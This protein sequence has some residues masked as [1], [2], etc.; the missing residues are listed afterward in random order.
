LNTELTDNP[1]ASVRPNARTAVG[2][3]AARTRQARRSEHQQKRR[4][5]PW[6]CG[7][8]AFCHH[9]LTC[10]CSR[11]RTTRPRVEGKG[12][13]TGGC[14][15]LRLATTYA[16]A[17]PIAVTVAHPG[18][19]TSGRCLY[20]LQRYPAVQGG[21]RIVWKSGVCLHQ[22]M[23]RTVVLASSRALWRPLVTSRRRA[24][25]LWGGA[26]S[27]WSCSRWE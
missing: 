10:R 7:R 4:A 22:S 27:T 2:L 11:K 9:H 24:W 3:R 14:D 25:Q 18:D 13:H 16:T 21:Q 1:R 17:W 12:R 5:L 23:P 19:C 8:S 20:G 6:Y 26:L 15:C